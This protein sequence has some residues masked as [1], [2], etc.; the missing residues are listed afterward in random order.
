MAEYLIQKTTLTSIADAIREKT[1]TT[2]TIKPTEM[3]SKIGE[4]SV[5][6]GGFDTSDPNT[7]KYIYMLDD[8]KNIIL[9][10]P[11]TQ[12]IPAYDIPNT[13]GG[14]HTVISS[15]GVLYNNTSYGFFRSNQFIIK[16]V[17]IGEN[18]RFFNNSMDKMFLGCVNFNSAI[19][20]PN[21]V[22]NA[23][24]LLRG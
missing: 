22:T 3:A 19:S 24:D 16:N 18:V 2:G 6:G 21:Y 4:I 10:S 17:T 1:G 20:I 12:N 8:N 15:S 23:H 5:G 14:Y 7:S 13:I 11:T 9:Y